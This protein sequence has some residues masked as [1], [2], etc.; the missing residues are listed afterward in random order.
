MGTLGSFLPLLSPSFLSSL[1]PL[2]PPIPYPLLLLP[3]FP[4]LSPTHHLSFPNLPSFPL[5]PLASLIWKQ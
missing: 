2:S 4:L 5:P 1:L 3:F